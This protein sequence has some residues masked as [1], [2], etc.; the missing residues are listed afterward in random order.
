LKHKTKYDEPFEVTVYEDADS[1]RPYIEVYDGL[2]NSFLIDWF[3][4][5][6]II[7][8]MMSSDTSKINCVNTA[9]VSIREICQKT[10]MSKPTICKHIRILEE[11]GIIIKQE[12][13]TPNNKRIANTYKLLN[14]VS[15][16]DCKTLNE[17][18]NVTNKIKSEVLK[19][20]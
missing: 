13:N 15:V 18:K 20:G 10:K 17:L 9:T 3:D 8:L 6:L 2:I 16:W 7:Y 12:N 11:K 4:K 1:N 14:Y 19:D 5:L